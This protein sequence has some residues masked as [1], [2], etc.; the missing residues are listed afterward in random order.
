[1]SAE[2]GVEGAGL[3]EPL[4]GVLDLISDLIITEPFCLFK[5]GLDV[6]GYYRVTRLTR[7]VGYQE[8]DPAAVFLHRLLDHPRNGMVGLDHVGELDGAADAFALSVAGGA[9]KH[10]LDGLGRL[11]DVNP[12]NDRPAPRGQHLVDQLAEALDL[13]RDRLDLQAHAVA[14]AA[15]GRSGGLPRARA[16]GGDQRSRLGGVDRHRERRVERPVADRLGA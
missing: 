4:C 9:Q 1:M 13:V 12:F 14:Q 15:P 7:I 5:I 3:A 10:A 16:G 11:V 2:V 6:P 8:G